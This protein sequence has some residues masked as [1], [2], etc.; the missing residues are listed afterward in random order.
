MELEIWKRI[1][2]IA[3]S[4]TKQLS[5]VETRGEIDSSNKVHEI[6][7]Q[8][9]YYK[10]NP[11][12]LKFVEVPNDPWNRKSVMA[13]LR[14]KKGDSKKTVIMIKIEYPSKKRVF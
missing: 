7:S 12:D 5:V 4:L 13:I 11:N 3:I 6:F 9:D 1:E 8:M 2:E 14:G 10:E